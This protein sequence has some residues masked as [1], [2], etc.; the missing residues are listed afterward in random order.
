MTGLTVLASGKGG[1]GKTFLAVSLAHALTHLGRRVLLVD[2]DLGLA[3]ID[4]QLGFDE[5]IGLGRAIAGGLDPGALVQDRGGGLSTLTGAGTGQ[6]LDGLATARL[7]EAVE[8][9][10]ALATSFDE[11][12]VDLP[13]GLDRVGPAFIGRARRL[14]LVGSNE[15]TS[16]TDNYALVKL[17]RGAAPRPLFVAN[18]VADA[19]EGRVAHAALARACRHFLDLDCVYLGAVRHDRRVPEAIRRQMP[20]CLRSP[21]AP[22]AADIAVLASRL[23]AE[24][25]APAR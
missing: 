20:L 7:E 11:V 8:R 14:L 17:T 25:T 10:A 16:L 5:P 9:L 22:A 23:S 13:S 15:P 24:P 3:N 18:A 21:Q 2:A 19:A 6:S 12:L 1:V 4:V